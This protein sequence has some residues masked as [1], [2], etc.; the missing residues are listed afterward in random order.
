MRV[1]A[2][3]NGLLSN[4]QYS[5]LTTV[6]NFNADVLFTYLVHPGTAVYVSYNTNQENV[7][8]GLCQHLA[9]SVECVPGSELLRT[10]GLATNDGRL[11]FIKVSYLFRR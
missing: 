7:D 1:I 11:F 10:R 9:G 6:K 8:P 2:Q 4:P 5:S 3:Y